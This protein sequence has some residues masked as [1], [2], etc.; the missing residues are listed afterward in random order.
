MKPLEEEFGAHAKVASRLMQHIQGQMQLAQ[1]MPKVKMSQC[2]E[3]VL[4]EGLSGSGKTFLVKRLMD[5]LLKSA[6]P[7]KS[8]HVKCPELFTA[9]TGVTEGRLARLLRTT[10]YQ[11]VFLDDVDA[12]ATRSSQNNTDSGITARGG[13]GIPV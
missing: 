1:A 7:V 8:C 10:E 6:A 4:L 12:I 11:V 5:S 13:S 9:D 3:H 2:R